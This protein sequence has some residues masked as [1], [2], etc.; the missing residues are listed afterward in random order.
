MPMY[1]Y[2]CLDCHEQFEILRSVSERKDPCECSHCGS[3]KKHPLGLSM[4]S[5]LGG[6]SSDGGGSSSTCSS[7]GFG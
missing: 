1:E 3:E 2:T 4:I 5:S 6:L 7:S